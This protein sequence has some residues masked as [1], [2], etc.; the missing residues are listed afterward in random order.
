MFY[1]RFEIHVAINLITR[2]KKYR[3]ISLVLFDLEN[4]VNNVFR[5]RNPD[6]STV[7]NIV[8]KTSR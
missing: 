7:I 6:I 8:L 5:P 3:A 2:N 1:I 4:L